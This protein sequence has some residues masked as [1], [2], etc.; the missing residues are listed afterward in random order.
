VSHL[1]LALMVANTAL[2]DVWKQ[3]AVGLPRSNTKNHSH[4]V[5]AEFDDT[6]ESVFL[7]FLTQKAANILF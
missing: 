5:Y 6:A 2:I 4:C 3:Q 7:P 1:I